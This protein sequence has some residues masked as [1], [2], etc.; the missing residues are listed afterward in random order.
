[1]DEEKDSTMV[2]DLL[3]FKAK[4][5]QIWERAFL[6]NDVFGYTLRVCSAQQLRP[7]EA[8]TC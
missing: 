4:L 1:M 6:K 2:V 8:H 3:A 5:D 7:C